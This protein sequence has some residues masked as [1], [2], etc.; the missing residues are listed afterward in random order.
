M[1]LENPNALECI[2]PSTNRAPGSV[3]VCRR[4]RDAAA[5]HGGTTDLAAAL[6]LQYLLGRQNSLEEIHKADLLLR[7]PRVLLE[8]GCGRADAARRIA[9][10]N[11]DMGVI[12]TDRFGGSRP[13][14][15]GSGYEKIASA[16]R[17]HRLPVQMA[18]L[19]NLV[20]LRA[21][22]EL[23]ACLP[24]RSVDA[25]LL[26]NPEPRVGRD[27]LARVQDRAL[28]SRIKPGPKRIVVLPFSRE[29]GLSACGGF[30]FDHD[31]DWS[32]GLGFIRGSGLAFRPDRSEQWG[33]DLTALSAYSRSS[34]QRQVYVWGD[35]SV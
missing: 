21:E 8:I 19:P 29:M 7:W 6:R 14:A 5:V 22:A 31:P 2:E 9:G 26:V 15:A 34:T 11:P 33:V 23:L 13:P 28:L 3:G 1:R 4:S 24:E 27:F 20:V 25:V 18:P 32:R 35:S 16:W 12:A 30:G 10:K 17:E